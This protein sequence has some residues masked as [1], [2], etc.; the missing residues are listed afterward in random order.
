MLGSF[1]G[2]TEEDLYL[3]DVVVRDCKIG[4]EGNRAFK[5]G[6]GLM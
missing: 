5:G 3:A 2:A 4:I 1:A 6:Q